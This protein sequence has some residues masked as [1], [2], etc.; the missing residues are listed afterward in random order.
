MLVKNLDYVFRDLDGDEIENITVEQ[1]DDETL[2]CDECGRAGRHLQ[3][4]TKGNL[5]L[6]DVLL[7]RLLAEP[8]RDEKALKEKEKL[9]RFKL[10][11]KIHDAGD[12]VEME[13]GDNDLL[14]KLIGKEERTLVVGQALPILDP[15]QGEDETKEEAP[16]DGDPGEPEDAGD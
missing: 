5:T 4:I 2:V 1:E 9:K 3:R 6:R 14:K 10:A 16:E 13:S 11:E 15:K 12:E 8:G 7:R